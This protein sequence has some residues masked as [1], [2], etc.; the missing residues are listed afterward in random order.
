MLIEVD[1]VTADAVTHAFVVGVSHYPFLDGPQM[2]DTGG[3]LGMANL[4][5]AA[6]SASEVVAWLLNEHHFPE[7]P[8]KDLRVLLSPVE[9]ETLHPDVLARMGG[10]PAPA[11]RETVRKEFTAFKDAC[12]QNPANRAFVFL[13]GHGIQLSSRGAILLLEDFATDEDGDLLFGAM[14]VMGCHAS[15]WATGQADHQVW[16][17]DAC[18]QRPEIVK[19]FESLTGAWAPGNITG[20][21]V[22]ATPILLSSGA[23]ENAF[24]DPQGLTLFTEALLW[25]LRGAGAVGADAVCPRWHVSSEQ[26]AKVIQA[27]VRENARAG[28]VDQS[29]DPTGKSVDVAVHQLETAPLVD[30]EVA[31]K[32]PDLDPLPTAV[33]KFGGTEAVAVE[34]GW[35]LRFRG[36]AGLYSLS[37][38]VPGPVPRSAFKLLSAAPPMCQDEVLVS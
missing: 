22:A 17:S 8:L 36:T 35:P 38:E 30:I 4:S 13:T 14:D 6:R 9:A 23:R 32:P 12:A 1:G 11:T 15:M 19:R 26:L 29:I 24:A 28:G 33:L 31:L 3:Q 2:T 20:G 7:A 16:F 34:P 25:G 27:R 21:D 10:Q 5:S 37:A 18:R